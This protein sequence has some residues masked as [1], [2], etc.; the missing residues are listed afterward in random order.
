MAGSAGSVVASSG[1]GSGTGGGGSTG[2]GGGPNTGGGGTPSIGGAPTP[3]GGG[4]QGSLGGYPACQ[5]GNGGPVQTLQ[6]GFPTTD[7]RTAS[8]VIRT[9]ADASLMIEVEGNMMPFLWQGPSLTDHFAVDTDV[10]LVF[11]GVGPGGLG[12]GAS[13]NVVRSNT[14]SAATFSG[15]NWAMASAAPDATYSFSMPEGFPT[16]ELV[17]T[18][19]CGAIECRYS[20]LRAT[21][22]TMTGEVE[23]PATLEVADWS[24]THLDGHYHQGSEYVFGA[25]LTVLGPTTLV[26][27]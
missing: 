20:I 2:T 25:V 5:P 26:E 1:A 18:S 3:M 13:W 21:V 12:G 15:S 9:V 27:Q 14:A 19:C 4:G 6:L 10:E 17:S 7:L 24:F 22:E 8:G 11:G 16:V 23:A